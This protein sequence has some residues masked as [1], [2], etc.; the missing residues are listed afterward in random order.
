MGATY[1]VGVRSSKR[2][3]SGLE[4]GARY[5]NAK[6]SEIGKILLATR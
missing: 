6:T 5:I 2:V 3:E 4:A 1:Q